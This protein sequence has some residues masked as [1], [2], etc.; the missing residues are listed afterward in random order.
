MTPKDSDPGFG[1]QKG[2]DVQAIEDLSPRMAVQPIRSLHYHR[3]TYV[4]G[5]DA[6]AYG[7]N[8]TRLPDL[9]AAYDWRPVDY[10]TYSLNDSER[11]YSATEG[12]CF[13]VVWAVRTV[14]DDVQ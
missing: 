6:S 5:T 4:I 9:D 1:T 12:E 10:R 8:S 14:D 7:L 11:D 3:R 13:A 2:S